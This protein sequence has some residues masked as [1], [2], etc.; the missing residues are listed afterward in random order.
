M[1]QLF[2][3]N[4]MSNKEVLKKV[5]EIDNETMKTDM[6]ID[7]IMKSI[8][9]LYLE[10]NQVIAIND[11]SL[12]I[13]SNSLFSIL[14]LF[15]HIDNTKKFIL[16]PN[17]EFLGIYSLFVKIYNE[18]YGSKCL[19]DTNRTYAHYKK[20]FEHSNDVYVIGSKEFYLE[21]LKDFPNA[22][23]L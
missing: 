9:Y 23:C 2:I 3:D 10:D 11:E 1:N 13:T 19:L 21:V 5:I 20:I 17:Y 4:L 16:F 15:A 22:I 12:I 6:T 18:V 14:K 7:D 8:E